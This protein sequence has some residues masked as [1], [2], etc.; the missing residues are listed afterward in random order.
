MMH[1]RHTASFFQRLLIESFQDLD[2]NNTASAWIQDLK[3]PPSPLPSFS[4]HGLYPVPSLLRIPYTIPRHS[5]TQ[6][7]PQAMCSL[8][9][10][11]G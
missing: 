10:R 4:P 11:G 3:P 1:C 7:G 6:Q 8:P 2:L 5:P 9:K